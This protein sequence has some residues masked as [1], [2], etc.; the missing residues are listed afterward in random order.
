MVDFLD[1]QISYLSAFTPETNTQPFLRCEYVDYVHMLCLEAICSEGEALG[2]DAN[3]SGKERCRGFSVRS[4]FTSLA[5]GQ[6]SFVW[7]WWRREG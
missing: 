1:T 3:V 7:V 6:T 4:Y 5:A 2:S